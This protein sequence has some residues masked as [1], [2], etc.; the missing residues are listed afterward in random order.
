MTDPRISGP[1]ARRPL[2]GLPILAIVGLALL[3]GVR[4]A[5]H[6]LGVIQEQ[7]FVNLLFVV[8][9][10]VVWVAVATVWSA[11]PLLSLTAAGAG[12]GATLALVHN[13]L[14]D[15][16]FGDESPRLGGALAGAL[17]SAAEELVMRGAVAVSSIA[18]GVVVGVLCGLV[19]WAI[20]AIALKR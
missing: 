1:V 6:D 18:M 19:A 4:G 2:L 11:R 13:V 9:P 3:A 10:L 12:Y 20:R 5:L 7:T 8:L 14:W 16:R 17:D 15:V